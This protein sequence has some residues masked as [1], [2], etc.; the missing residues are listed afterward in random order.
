MIND[1]QTLVGAYTTDVLG[2][3]HPL[4]IYDD[5]WGSLWV[6]GEACG[7]LIYP[8]GVVRAQ[9]FESAYEICQDEIM[10]RVPEEDLLDAYGLYVLEHKGFYYLCPDF[11]TLNDYGWYETFGGLI[12]TR[13]VIDR[14]VTRE[15]TEFEGRRLIAKHELDLVEGYEYQSN[16][17]GTG[18]VT[19]DLNGQRL[20]ELTPEVADRLGITIQVTED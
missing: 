1:D 13:W 20:E 6:Y 8:R 17:T 2:K 19:Y 16:A 18:I 11:D 15:G 9:S 14:F 7:A 4:K 12:P 5:S 3:R 10:S